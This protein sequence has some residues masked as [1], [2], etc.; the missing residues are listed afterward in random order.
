[1]HR[2]VP[3][4]EW[5]RR[6]RQINEFERILVENGTTILK[7]FLHISRQEQAGRLHARLDDPSK[8]WKFDPGDLAERAL[9][10]DYRAAY[11]DAIARCSTEQ[12]PWFVVPADSK[13]VAQVL[14]L[15]AIVH[16]LERLDPRYPPA[17]A[18]VLRMKDR[19]E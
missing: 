7:F 15:R 1:V 10:D 11:R 9:W 12:A 19:I 2:L 18:E 6:Y 4:A 8:N 5:S 14:V 17:D 13:R 3:E 16:A